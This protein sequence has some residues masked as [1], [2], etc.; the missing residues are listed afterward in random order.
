MTI[1]GEFGQHICWIHSYTFYV[2]FYVGTWTILLRCAPTFFL[3]HEEKTDVTYVG[4]QW[5]MDCLTKTNTQFS[6]T[7]SIFICRKVL[8]SY[9]GKSEQPHQPTDIIMVTSL[10]KKRQPSYAVKM[11]ASSSGNLNTRSKKNGANLAGTGQ[12]PTDLTGVYW[13]GKGQLPMD[14]R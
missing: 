10:R 12:L 4:F 11:T 14:L 2:R 3:T 8:E 6:S 9:T 5:L 13:A 1:A 7:A